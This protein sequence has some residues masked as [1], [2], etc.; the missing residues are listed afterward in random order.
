MQYLNGSLFD[1]LAWRA[2]NLTECLNLRTRENVIVSNAETI[3][4]YAIGWCHG[5]SIVCRPKTDTIAVMFFTNEI[6][7][8]THFTV[9][10][11]K[12]VFPEIDI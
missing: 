3:R 11:F 8:W 10:E 4:K 7:W 9:K 5:E 1:W 12:Q 6:E 2:G